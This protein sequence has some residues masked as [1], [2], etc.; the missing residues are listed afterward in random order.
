MT[1]GEPGDNQLVV[2]PIHG[3]A[4]DRQ[5]MVYF[6]HHRLLYASDTLVL[7]DNGSLYDPELMDEVVQAVAREH[8]DVDRVYAM[9]QTPIA[10]TQAAAL[11]T[12]A[13]AA[14]PVAAA[15]PPTGPM[16]PL[17]GF[18]GSFACTGTFANGT[19]IQSDV[20]IEL[21]DKAGV[22][23]KHHDD[24]APSADYHAIEVWTHQA[25]GKR[26]VA[27]I[28]DVTGGVRQ[29]TSPGLT[30]NTLTW[31]S[32]AGAAAKEQFVY[33]TVDS[34]SF[35]LDWRVNKAGQWKVGDSLTCTRAS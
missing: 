30:G 14:A 29:F 4:T 18:L 17:A 6:P 26:Y 33:T 27:T 32:G 10:Y 23:I 25:D 21:D 13:H 22:I 28:T 12:A 24:T 1:I 15:T 34:R 35:R 7:N 5:Y 11:V 2:Y 8:L 31:T 20:H 9:H 3:A 16:G 19:P